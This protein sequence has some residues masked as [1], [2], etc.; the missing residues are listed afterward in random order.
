VD[1]PGVG[2]A[3]SLAIGPIVTLIDFTRQ[4][5][6]CDSE[7]KGMAISPDGFWVAFVQQEFRGDGAF[8]TTGD[9]YVQ[10][11]QR[12]IVPTHDN[13]VFAVDDHGTE[14]NRPRLLWM[15]P[16]K[17]QITLPNTS[18][19]GL[20]KSSYQGIEIQVRFQPDDPVARERFLQCFGLE[21][22]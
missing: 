2:A 8:V 22:R 17:L 13:D 9:D 20:P 3:L 15:S 7:T 19:T 5:A 1:C 21:H 12:G 6:G 10:L 16:Q 4:K 14:E 18:L 11:V